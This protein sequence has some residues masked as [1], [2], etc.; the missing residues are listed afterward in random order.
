VVFG[1]FLMDVEH[2]YR[3]RKSKASVMGIAS[4]WKGRVKVKDGP[5]T[6]TEIKP[7]MNNDI[8]LL[9]ILSASLQKLSTQI[10][11]SVID[12]DDIRHIEG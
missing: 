2:V 10:I 6:N 12:C 11:W 7:H 1:C 5:N 3:T 4:H 9:A 8:A